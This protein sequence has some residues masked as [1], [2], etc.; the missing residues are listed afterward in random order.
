MIRTRTIITGVVLAVGL[1]ADWHLAR[2]DHHAPGFSLNRGLNWSY[3]W[4]ATALLFAIVG[5][6]IARLWPAQRW[7]IGVLA[8]AFAIV[9]AQVLEPVFESIVYQGHF[10]FSTETARWAAFGQALCASIPV[11]ALGL[12]L[13]ARGFAENDVAR[14]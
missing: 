10:G 14:L 12:W 8:L 5:C 1:H 9:L 3:H 2:P 6:V 13:G 11:Y 4:V 7:R